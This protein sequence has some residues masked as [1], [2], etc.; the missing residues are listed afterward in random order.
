ML[1]WSIQHFHLTFPA[2]PSPRCPCPLAPNT[3]LYTPA[4]KTAARGTSVSRRIF[5]NSQSTCVH[6]C[7]L[8][9]M[10]ERWKANHSDC[11]AVKILAQRS[12]PESQGTLLEQQCESCQS[13]RAQ[14]R[15]GD[16]EEKRGGGV[17]RTALR[18]RDRRKEEKPK[19]I[20]DKCNVHRT[21]KKKEKGKK[22]K[23]RQI[24]HEDD[25]FPP[26]LNMQ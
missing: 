21:S 13:P 7:Q 6:S 1:I 3:T 11:F 15:G 2:P 12:P 14:I 24:K 19:W 18:K 23:N 10:L 8:Q 16:R 25:R 4:N 26:T 20:I 5:D 9:H 17:A 22:K